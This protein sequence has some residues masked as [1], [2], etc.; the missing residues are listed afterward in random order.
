MNELHAKAIQ[1]TARF[2]ERKG[3]KVLATQ[4]ESPEGATADLVADDDGT[5]CFI[6]VTAVE[7]SAGGFA[8]GHTERDAW[9]I[10]AASWLAGNT[11]EGDVSV[12][13]DKCDMIIVANDR[14]LLRY[15]SNVLSEG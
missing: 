14:A 13:F 15:H 5:I 8:D 6:D 4:W 1:A 7:Y 11:P 3:Y 2:I 10:L 12:R 9:E